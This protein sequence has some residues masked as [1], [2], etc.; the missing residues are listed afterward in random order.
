ME[1]NGMVSFTLP[2]GRIDQYKGKFRAS[3]FNG[4]GAFS[5][6]EGAGLTSLHGLF[7]EGYVNR[8]GRKVYPDG[9]HYIGELRF[10]LE[11]GKGFL[12]D[13]IDESGPRQVAIWK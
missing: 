9:H 6:G 5:W 13:T 1:G 3:R 7:E 10:D 2:S 11:H 12:C 4:M 8:V